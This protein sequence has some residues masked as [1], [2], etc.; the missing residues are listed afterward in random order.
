MIANFRSVSSG[1]LCNIAP[2][3][4][5]F[6]QSGLIMRSLRAGMTNSLLENLEFLK[7]NNRIW[8]QLLTESHG[9]QISI[10]VIE[11]NHQLECRVLFS[12]SYINRLAVILSLPSFV[13]R[14]L[15][16][17]LK[18]GCRKRWWAEIQWYQA[19]LDVKQ[20]SPA[21]TLWPHALLTSLNEKS[22][23]RDANTA[24]QK[25]SSRRRLPSRRRRTA[26]I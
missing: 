22:A 15:F 1:I 16:V 20:L 7:C 21:L 24:R 12:L 5:V 6:S 17:F 23:Q 18:T 2:V 8:L 25:F 14:H 4:G 26:K 10:T 13:F 11:I 3:D 19:R 9:D